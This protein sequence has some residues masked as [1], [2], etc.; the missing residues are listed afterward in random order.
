MTLYDEVLY[1][2]FPIYYTHP[3]RLSTIAT[4]MGMK[5]APVDQC[6]VLEIG[7]FDGINLASMAVSLP[8]SEF[9]GVDLASTAIAR[10]CAMAK[11]LGLENLIL[12]HADVMEMAVDYGVFDYIIVHGV[13]AWVPPAVARR[14]MAICK[15]S[16]APQGVAYVSYNTLPGCHVRLMIREMMQFHNRDFHDPQQ[17]M[18]QGL[19]LLKVLSSSLQ[20]ENEFYPQFLKGEFERLS[21]RSLEALYHDELSEVF[22]PI[23]FHQFMEQAQEQNLQFLGEA[24]FFDMM[25]RGLTPKAVEILDRIG[26]DIVLREQYLDFMRGRLFRKTLLCHPDIAV[27]HNVKADSVR[28]FAVSTFAKGNS[29]GPN[30]DRGTK[31]TFQTLGGAENHVRRP[32][33]ASHVLVP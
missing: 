19:N 4:L 23:Y 12:R 3:N 14:I 11:D 18:Q 10:G 8:H 15:G 20:N 5:P 30:P 9:V 16:L 6:R 31:E 1:P 26:G 29:S 25:P 24:D 17:Q 13:Y 33:G 7:C 27:N 32:P 22:S 28:S 21:Q 2:S